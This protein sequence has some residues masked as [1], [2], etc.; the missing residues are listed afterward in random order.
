[1]RRPGRVPAA[2]AIAALAAVVGAGGALAGENLKQRTKTM[3]VGASDQGSVTA[4]CK[5]DAKVISGGFETEFDTIAMQ[6]DVQI[7]ES[8][9]MG[10]KSWTAGAVNVAPSASGDLT[11][12]AYCRDQRLKRRSKATTVAQNE[13]GSVTAK[14]PKGTRAV[15]GGFE[16]DDE[17]YFELRSSQRKGGRGWEVSGHNYG[18]PGELEATVYCR[19]GPKLKTASASGTVSYANFPDDVYT[20]LEASCPR[21]R[22]SVSGGFETDGPAVVRDSAKLGKG[23]RLAATASAVLPFETI[24]VTVFAYC[25]KK[26]PKQ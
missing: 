15:S 10:R 24:A 26:K 12:F 4:K 1:M 25:E 8:R 22:T 21:G 6:P 17:S 9:R 19:A 14:C 5:G 20:A 23:W 3:S 7:N 2:L 11:A 13:V 18:Q 16:G